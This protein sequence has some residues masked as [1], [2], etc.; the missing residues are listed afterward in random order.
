MVAR[1]SALKVVELPGAGREVRADGGAQV[2]L[3]GGTHLQRAGQP[4]Q[5]D[6]PFAPAARPDGSGARAAVRRLQ[7]AR[8]L[9]PGRLRC[10]TAWPAPYAGTSDKWSPDRARC[11]VAGAAAAPARGAAPGAAYPAAS[12]P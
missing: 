1:D 9:R 7:S 6:A 2:R 10:H 4:E 12:R 5:G 3:L 8:G 11:S